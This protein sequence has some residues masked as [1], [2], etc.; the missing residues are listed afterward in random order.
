MSKY[1]VLNLRGCNMT[2][3]L[4]KP[5]YPHCDQYNLSAVEEEFDRSPVPHYED[6]PHMNWAKPGDCEKFNKHYQTKRR[7]VPQDLP[8]EEREKRCLLPE[9]QP[10]KPKKAKSKPITIELKI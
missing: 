3:H 2:R 7:M 5:G 9:E 1:Q 8:H 4:D 10:P 6:E